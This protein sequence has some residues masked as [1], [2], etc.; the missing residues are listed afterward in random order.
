MKSRAVC[1]L[2]WAAAL[3]VAA[4]AQ[5]TSTYE[6]G[7]DGV[8]YRVT[9]RVVQRSVP[10]TEYQTRE[11]KVYRPQVTTQCQ[12]YQQT[13]L[14]PVT[15]YRWVSRLH[16]VWNPFVSPYWRHSLEPVTRWEARPGVVQIPTARTQWVEETRTAR[17]PVT[18]YRTVN[19]EYTSRVAVSVPPST[20]PATLSPVGST[21]SI[22]SRP[23]YGS[24]RM[25][26][27]P[28][29]E[30]SPWKSRSGSMTYTR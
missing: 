17:V 10:T 5:E 26:S 27:D 19:E 8:Q 4:Q 1:T 23:A 9:R 22:A 7:P 12:S 21:T 29:R 30:P 11:Q 13:Y 18:T 28:P 16:G 24:Q 2:V 14:T 20:T 3:A 6:T 15:E 25:E